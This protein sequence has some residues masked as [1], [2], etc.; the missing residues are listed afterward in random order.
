MSIIGHYVHNKLGPVLIMLMNDTLVQMIDFALFWSD[1]IHT[2]K[3]YFQSYRQPQASEVHRLFT[4]LIK[5]SAWPQITTSRWYCRWRQDR[6]VDGLAVDGTTEFR[7]TD[8][9]HWHS[10]WQVQIVLFT[11]LNTSTRV[12]LRMIK[13][14]RWGLSVLIAASYHNQSVDHLSSVT[15]VHESVAAVIRI[16]LHLPCFIIFSSHR[17]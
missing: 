10:W 7:A 15:I 5:L 2:M 4:W 3:S 17:T 1:N 12:G 9:L 16:R 8:S 13:R 14:Q 6:V 11:S